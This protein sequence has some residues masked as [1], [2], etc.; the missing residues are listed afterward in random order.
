M[1][2]RL[3]W[4]TNVEFAGILLAQ[5]RG[6][7]AEA[8]IDLTVKGWEEDISSIDDVVTGK[9]QIGV[10]EGSSIIEARAQ[11]H[12][13][14]A[15]AVQFQRA[16]ACLISKKTTGIKTPGDLEGKRIGTNSTSDTLMTT[17]VLLYGGL[18]YEDITPVEVGWNVQPL[19]DDAV[20]VLPGYMNNE[21][22]VL[23]AQ[24]Y[25]VTYMP[26]FKYGYDF[27]T[28]VYFVSETLI[29]EQPELIR[30]FL[31]V[32]LR[33]WKAAFHDPAA[34]AA[35]I[36]EKYYPDGS[37]EH[38]TKS[39]N[40]FHTLATIGVGDALIG[41]MEER[42]WEKGIDILYTYQQIE[43]KIPARDVFTLEFLPKASQK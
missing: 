40:V 9:A 43:Q 39:L 24:G 33:G 29:A 7:Y 32:T 27:Y 37:V 3:N 16:P 35:R 36:V 42:F 2:I 15:I 30:S 26:A 23:K 13:I 18:Q 14:K 11:G 1:T 38:Q 10:G 21:P 22:L 19:L 6:W 4:V 34:T 8:G 20:D 5:E 28:G 17:I 12:N 31:D 41:F 25:D